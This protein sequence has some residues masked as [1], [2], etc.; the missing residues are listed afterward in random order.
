M[1]TGK[2]MQTL[3]NHRHGFWQASLILIP[4]DNSNILKDYNAKVGSL[5][6]LIINNAFQ[7]QQLAELRD[8]LLPMLMNGQ[9]TIG[10]AQKMVEGNLSI[11]AEEKG[12]YRSQK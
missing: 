4:N 3:F 1:S 6:E 8:W 12:V 10:D 11:A 5:Y 9:V 2:K 7:S